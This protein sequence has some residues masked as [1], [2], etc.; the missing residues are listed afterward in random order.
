MVEELHKPARRHYPRRKVDIR[1]YDD[2]WSADLI[3]MSAYAKVNKNHHF[4]LTVIDN[5]SK[6]A[7]AIPTKTK[8]GRDVTAAMRTVLEQGRQPR[9]LHVDR[10]KEFYNSSFKNLMD[11]YGI[12]M[13]STFSNLK[14]CLAERFNRSLGTLLFKEFSFRGT[15]KW[16]DILP[17]LVSIYNTRKH[18]TIGM[19]PADVTPAN[20][21]RLKKIYQQRQ[22]P[23]RKK[24]KFK[25]GDKVRA[26]K[27][28]HVF[29]KGFTPNFTPEISEI[30]AV[31]PTSLITY[32]LKDYQNEPIE[33]GFYEEELAPVKFPDVYLVEKVLKRRGNRLFVKWLGFDSS[34]NSW[35]TG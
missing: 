30:V 23:P 7:W 35:I 3:D 1:D 31:K 4:I 2:T 12:H 13:Y 10:G 11:E 21:H 27:H 24:P 15:Y 26:S 32:R 9:R 34:H 20:A 25:V 16:I 5:F 28:K 33:G 18:R 29:E 6:Y 22:R 17:D 19:R 8:S 14:S